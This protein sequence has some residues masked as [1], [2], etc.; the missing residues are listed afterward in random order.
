MSTA[1]KQRREEQQD[2]A[3][4]VDELRSARL[5]AYKRDQLERE[6]ALVPATKVTPHCVPEPHESP[7]LLASLANV[8]AAWYRE[9]SDRSPDMFLR[10]LIEMSGSRF[11]LMVRVAAVDALGLTNSTHK[12]VLEQLKNLQSDPD[13]SVS[14]SAS[15]ALENLGVQ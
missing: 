15:D 11:P 10:A 2:P 13:A 5:P 4:L 12:I 9:G 1:I 7:H 8:L 6:L 3:A 14:A